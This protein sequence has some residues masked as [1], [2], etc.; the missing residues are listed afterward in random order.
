[1]SDNTPNPITGVDVTV[2]REIVEQIWELTEL[3]YDRWIGG[4]PQVLMDL[5][6]TVGREDRRAIVIEPMGDNRGADGAPEPLGEADQEAFDRQIEEEL[7][8]MG[9]WEESEEGQAVYRLSELVESLLRKRRDQHREQFEILASHLADEYQ[10]TTNRWNA[11][12][13][14]QI[15]AEA[16]LIVAG[17]KPASADERRMLALVRG[18]TP[19]IE[20]SFLRG[21]SSH[22]R[23][24]RSAL[25]RAVRAQKDGNVDAVDKWVALAL[26]SA[27]DAC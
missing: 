11:S 20:L 18:M 2:S 3:A 5:L 26:D 21:D 8:A 1:M 10:R 17:E 19:A 13:R 14:A 15:T 9:A 12:L 16:T 27:V 25:Q 23:A 4:P 24:T 7:A 22:S 6:N